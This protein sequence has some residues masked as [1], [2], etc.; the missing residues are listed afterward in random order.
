[1]NTWHA[2]YISEFTIILLKLDQL[3][4]S[5]TYVPQNLLMW[6]VY[7]ILFAFYYFELQVSEELLWELFVQAGPVGK[8]LTLAYYVLRFTI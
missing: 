5:K 8:F 7:G 1:M 2:S 3:V 4:Y 6:V